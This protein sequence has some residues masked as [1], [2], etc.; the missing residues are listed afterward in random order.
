MS[1]ERDDIPL[2]TRYNGQF[3]FSR[4]CNS[5]RDKLPEGKKIVSFYFLVKNIS[6]IIHRTLPPSACSIVGTGIGSSFA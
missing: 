4:C 1:K 3:L 6:A 2:W 5:E